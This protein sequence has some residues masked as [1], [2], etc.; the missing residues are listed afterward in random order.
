[1]R[2]NIIWRGIF[3]IDFDSLG[4]LTHLVRKVNKS[5]QSRNKLFWGIADHDFWKMWACCDQYG[6]LSK[7]INFEHVTVSEWTVYDWT[8]NREKHSPSTGGFRSSFC[9]GA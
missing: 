9:E 3:T 1:M 8:S 4:T 7:T 5:N 6:L 2:E